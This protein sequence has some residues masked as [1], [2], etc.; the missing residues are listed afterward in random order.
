[1]TEAGTMRSRVALLALA[2]GC[3][4]FVAYSLAR[5]AATPSVLASAWTLWALSPYLAVALLAFTLRGRASWWLLAA[6]A[7]A[8]GAGPAAHWS[9]M[10][11]P[12]AMDGI[13]AM[14]LPVYQ[15][16]VLFVAWVIALIRQVRVARRPGGTA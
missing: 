16:I 12:D 9:M 15:G 6:N 4:A 8:L 13:A 1:M 5:M 14:I 10:R 3:G 7:V 2:A 11:H